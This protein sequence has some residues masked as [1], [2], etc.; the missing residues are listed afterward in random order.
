[1]VGLGELGRNDVESCT[2]TS[3]G[4]AGDPTSLATRANI[5]GCQR[6]ESGRL[7]TRGAVGDLSITPPLDARLVVI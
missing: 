5:V 1:M 4:G 3:H 6:G 2:V 7:C